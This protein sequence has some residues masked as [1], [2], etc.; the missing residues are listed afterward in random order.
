MLVHSRSI[1]GSHVLLSRTLLLSPGAV[2]VHSAW[3]DQWSRFSLL[4]CPFKVSVVLAS[5]TF[6]VVLLVLQGHGVGLEVRRKLKVR[7]L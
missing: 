5:V 2:A 3:C 7:V 4:D 6:Y 1:F